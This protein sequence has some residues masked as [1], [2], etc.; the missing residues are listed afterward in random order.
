MAFIFHDQLQRCLV[1]LVKRLCLLIVTV[2]PDRPH[3]MD[4]IFCFQAKARS[5]NSTA[6]R[7]VPDGIAGFC[8][9]NISS[10]PE[11]SPAECRR[12][13]TVSDTSPIPVSGLPPLRQQANPSDCEKRCQ[14]GTSVLWLFPVSVL[15]IYSKY[16]AC[17]LLRRTDPPRFGAPLYSLLPRVKFSVHLV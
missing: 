9:F 15:S 14:C 4:D 11:D 5:Y 3:S 13:R 17:V 12:A 6:G 8:Q 16:I 7:T 1:A 2:M 10:G